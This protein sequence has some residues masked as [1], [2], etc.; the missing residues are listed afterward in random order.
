MAEFLQLPNFKG[1]KVAAGEL[2]PPG[3]VRVTLLSIPAERLKDLPPK[4]G[5]TVT[6]ELPCRKF[7]DDKE[8]KKRKAEAKAAVDAPGADTQVE[9]VVRDK[10][11][12]KDGAQKKR[13]VRVGTPVHPASEHVS[14]PIPLNHVKPLKILANE[15]YV[16][17]NA[18]AGGE[19]VQ[20][21]VD[22]AF[23][24]EGH[25]NNGVGFLACRP[26]LAHLVLRV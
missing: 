1:C 7:L 24:N 23:A 14:S 11:A 21:N 5:D 4:T 15:H 18:F 8:K 2:L 25:G 19:G 12:S 6:A 26:S 3:S 16:S 10:G 17:P 22:D 9:K 13:R 20:E